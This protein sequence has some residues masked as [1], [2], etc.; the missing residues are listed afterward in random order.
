[1]KQSV[2]SDQDPSFPTPLALILIF[3]I[4]LFSYILLALPL[5]WLAQNLH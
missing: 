5:L 1:M 2:S 4:I 3:L